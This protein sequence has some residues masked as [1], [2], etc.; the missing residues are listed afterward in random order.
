MNAQELSEKFGLITE[1]EILL[2]QLVIRSVGSTRAPIVLL[3]TGRG[4]SL[5]AVLEEEECEYVT[6]IEKGEVRE[7]VAYVAEAGFRNHPTYIVN[8]RPDSRE[9]AETFQDDSIAAVLLDSHSTAEEVERDLAIWTPKVKP[10]SGVIMVHDYGT[11]YPLWIAT[12]K[13][14]DR[15]VAKKGIKQ[16]NAANCLVVFRRVVA[17]KRRGRRPRV[18]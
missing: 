18:Q 7:I 1:E 16:I 5:L 6:V 9:I 10:T 3:G 15:F 12:K 14:V 17:P 4:T 11:E 8:S 2:I 13:G